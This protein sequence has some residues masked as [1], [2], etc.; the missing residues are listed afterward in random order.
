MLAPVELTQHLLTLL[1][2]AV[3]PLLGPSSAWVAI[4]LLTVLVRVAL[5]PLAIAQARAGRVQ[6][7]LQPEVAKLR[8]RFAKKPERLQAAML[9]LYRQRGV[10]VLAGSGCLPVLLQLVQLPV[11][12]IVYR[13]I[14]ASAFS[15][16]LFGVPLATTLWAAPA[17]LLLAL[18]GVL[19]VAAALSSWQAARNARN[20][21]ATAEVPGGRSLTAVARVLPFATIP[22]AAWL[23]LAVVV[24][25]AAGNLFT[26]VQQV[27]LRVH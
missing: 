18:V 12:W 4:A 10:G 13:V 2:S 8:K 21:A 11:I 19:G 22:V 26:V 5:L 6:A 7:E 25:L 17:P 9:D 14:R 20:A 23:P 15:G 16:A 27:L 1:D 3:R 24:Y